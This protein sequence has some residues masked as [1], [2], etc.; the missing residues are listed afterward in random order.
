VL[1]KLP[2]D[3]VAHKGMHTA[4]E[5]WQVLESRRRSIQSQLL[6][7]PK[8]PQLLFSMGRIVQQLGLT[9]GAAEYYRKAVL[10]KDDYIE[11]RKHLAITW[12]VM[13]RYQDAIDTL[14]ALLSIKPGDPEAPY[15]IA[16]I[17]A[18][19]NKVEMSLAWLKNA[20]SNGYD[21]W[22]TLRKD[23]NLANIRRTE[24]FRE[25]ITR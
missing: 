10:Y 23:A 6:E 5:Q 19:Q 17:Y 8:D 22:N 16:S 4:N 9:E 20:V 14:K 25:L 15:T 12:A 11:A 3:P 13:G 18:R 1:R 24:Y 2:D 21:D 7:N